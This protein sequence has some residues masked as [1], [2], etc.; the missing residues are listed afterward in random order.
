IL[1]LFILFCFFKTVIHAQY[2]HKITSSPLSSTAGDSRSVN[3]VDINNDNYIDCFISNGLRG[4]Q[5][6]MLYLNDRH[7][8][9]IRVTTDTITHDGKP[10]DGASFADVDNDGDLDVFIVNWYNQNNLFYF[11][12]GH[13]NFKQVTDE[14]FVNNKG[15]SETAA[16]GDYNKDGFVDLY[17]TNSEGYKYNFLYINDKKGSFTRIMEGDAVTDTC[18]SRCATWCDI[19][20]D[21][22][23]DLFVTNENKQAENLYRNDGGNLVKITTGPLLNDGGN[24]TSASWSDMDNDGDMDV[25]LTNDGGFN[26]LFKNDG[27]FNFTK[28]V[29]DTVASTPA[30]S[31][32]CAWSDVDNDGDEDLF[33]TNSFNGKK[34]MLNYFYLNNGDGT[35][36]R[37]TSDIIATD[38]AWSYG[39]A[40]GD[41]DNDGFQDLVVATCRFDKTDDVDLL[42][43]NNGNDNHW[44]SLKLI[45]TKSNRAAIGARV[46]VK[47]KING[48]DVEQMREISAQNGYCS[49]NDLRV[50]VG[51]NKAALIDE[52]K[53]IWPL[54]LTQTFKKIKTDQFLMITEGKDLVPNN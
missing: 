13:G 22:D 20:N 49:Q 35:F 5:N 43:H 41:Y 36:I 19:D 31:F 37:N 23:P 26:S 4:G 25:F 28:I 24:T 48:K 33:V 21:N 6:N 27:H 51:L 17:V 47:A 32:S 3:W 1:F 45:G 30:H 39:C 54:G 14:S 38:T 44:I 29:S 16:F 18:Y 7:G 8:N 15:Y 42:Y 40:F 52:I 11:N 53:I 10:S 12:D 46:Y 2:F 50:H 9:F 34:R